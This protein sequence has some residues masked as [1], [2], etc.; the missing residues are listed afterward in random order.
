MK[1]AILTVLAA[2]LASAVA[3]APAQA[4]DLQNEVSY[5]DLNIHSA[6][7]AAT[8][9]DRI[10]TSVD[11][12]CARSN[13]IR[14]VQGVAACKRALISDVVSQLDSR[15]AKQAAQTLAAKS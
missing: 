15:G 8:L 1:T 12:T 3:V 10:Q 13:D 6:A 4:K 9:A 14:D 11:R 5:A 7:G 2:S